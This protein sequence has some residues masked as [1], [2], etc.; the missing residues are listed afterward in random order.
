MNQPAPPAIIA[1][2]KNLT[3]DGVLGYAKFIIAAATTIIVSII[4]F[5]PEGD[6]QRYAQIAL[7]VLGSLGV[8]FVPNAVK[9]VVVVPVGQA[10][11]EDVQVDAVVVPV[12]PAPD[13]EPLLGV[14][15]PPGAEDPPGK[16]EAE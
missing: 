14:V 3:P 12:D 5:L 15:Q 13:P 1:S 6:Y 4:P 11:A 9:N 16:H 8:L 7:A 2:T 10:Q